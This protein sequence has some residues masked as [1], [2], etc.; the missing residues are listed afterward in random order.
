MAIA[1]SSAVS[2]SSSSSP[3]WCRSSLPFAARAP[4]LVGRAYTVDRI[5]AAVGA[6]RT[7]AIVFLNAAAPGQV[8]VGVM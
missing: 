5:V 8:C 2:S 3:W 1:S 7:R 6:P 4:L